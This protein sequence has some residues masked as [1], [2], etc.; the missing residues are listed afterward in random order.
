MD[1]GSIAQASVPVVKLVEQQ[2]LEA[3]I[4]LPVVI[5]SSVEIGSK[6]SIQIG[7]ESYFG[8]VTAKIRELDAATRTQTRFV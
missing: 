1:P 7:N 6:H 8:V 5:A 4:G 3:W 2:H